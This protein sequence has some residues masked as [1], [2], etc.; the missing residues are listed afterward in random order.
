MKK[1]PSGCNHHCVICPVT[2][3]FQTQRKGGGH[4]EDGLSVVSTG[5]VVIG[6]S[7]REAGDEQRS[8]RVAEVLCFHRHMVLLHSNPQ[9][10]H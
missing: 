2:S 1:V 9:S 3:R 8:V 10:E 5:T 7:Y 4:R 6:Y